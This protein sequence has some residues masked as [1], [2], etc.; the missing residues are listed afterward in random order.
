MLEPLTEL[1]GVVNVSV[2]GRVTNDWAEFI[3][4]CMQGAGGM[5]I[6]KGTFTHRTAMEWAELS[7]KI[8]GNRK[9]R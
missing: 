7:A 1:R 2:V 6:K 9:T 8:K 4:I 5:S 3:K